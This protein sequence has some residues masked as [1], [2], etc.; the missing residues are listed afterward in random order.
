MFFPNQGLLILEVPKC[1]SRTLVLACKKEFGENHF[2]GH[3]SI[4]EVTK[5]IDRE[6]KKRRN[7][8]WSVDKVVRIIREP[9]ERFVSAINYSYKSKRQSL[10]SSIDMMLSGKPRALTSTQAYWVDVKDVPLYTFKI[11]EMD[12]ALEFLG[13]HLTDLHENKSEPVYTVDEIKSHPK[14]DLILER[15]K[16]D[17]EMWNA[18]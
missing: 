4:R 12:K 15:Y 9:H 8:R 14:Y 6:V 18:S 7:L 5:R 11:G 1:G 13:C 2:A 16:P 17:F 10:D 3:H